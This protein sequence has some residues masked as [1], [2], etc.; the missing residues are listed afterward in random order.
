MSVIFKNKCTELYLGK[1]N[2]GVTYSIGSYFSKWH[3]IHIALGFVQ[4]FIKLPINSGRDECD[5]PEYGF[6]FH[7]NG[8]W[9]YYGLNK[10]WA[11]RLPWFEH[12]WARTS[13]LLK[14]GTW[15][16]D[17]PNN[18]QPLDFSDGDDIWRETHP[19]TYRLN[20]GTI[21][22]RTATIKVSEREWHRKWF[23][24]L[25]FTAKKSKTIDVSFSDEIGERS[26]SWKGG[27]TGCG[28]EILPNETPLMCLKRMERERK[29]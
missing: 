11:W 18:K 2:F 4:A 6:M 29:F 13:Y 8:F 25:K 3:Q 10:Q 17:T 23:A 1:C 26:G 15:K 20:N 22:N 12:Q 21:Q 7:N 27:T 5:N 28:Y 24:W 16:H 19:Y 9:I 14:D